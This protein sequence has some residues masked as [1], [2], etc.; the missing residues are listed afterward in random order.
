MRNKLFIYLMGIVT[1][2]L[3]PIPALWALWY[4]AQIDP[5]TVI[6]LQGFFHV[7]TLLG[8]EWGFF[9]AALCLAFFQGPHFKE[10]LA[11]Q[12]TMLRSLKLNK[13]DA[14][15]LSF[16]AGFGEEILF[17]SGMQHWLGI[18]LTS[19]VFVA[20]HGYFNPKEKRVSAYGFLIL[21]FILS[22]GFWLSD[23][24]IWFCIAAH[25]SYDLLL[26]LFLTR[27]PG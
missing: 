27:K 16:C 21:P 12:H 19:I 13:F 7:H 4:F 10:E 3:F 8:L 25:F 20:I 2:V 14:F 11:Q 22:L 6:D 23:L 15:F 1:L 5:W 17:R 9:Y 26:F 18:I 24:G